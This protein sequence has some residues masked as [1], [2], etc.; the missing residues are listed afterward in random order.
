MTI[1][2]L[3]LLSEELGE[4]LKIQKLAEL[5]LNVTK[6]ILMRM[7]NLDLTP[8]LKAQLFTTI[9]VIARHLYRLSISGVSLKPFNSTPSIVGLSLVG[10]EYVRQLN[11]VRLSLHDLKMEEFHTLPFHLQLEFLDF[12]LKESL[13]SLGNGWIHAPI[14]S[15]VALTC[16]NRYRLF[17]RKLS[18]ELKEIAPDESD[19]Y[20][21]AFVVIKIEMP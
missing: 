17:A 7:Y 20:T 1:Q 19:T 5:C 6:T 16:L 3:R 10:H 14:I 15:K 8:K 13:E 9:R 12:F 18:K 4:L 2:H 11:A 21:L